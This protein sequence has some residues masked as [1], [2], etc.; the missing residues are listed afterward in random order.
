MI[1]IKSQAERYALLIANNSIF[2][3]KLSDK[4]YSTK[5]FIWLGEAT[6][7]RE[8]KNRVVAYAGNINNIPPYLQNV[9]NKDIEQGITE[10]FVIVF[11]NWK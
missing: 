10:E 7:E 6:L 9:I 2:G 8:S 5:Y 4:R 3:Y 1:N 11:D